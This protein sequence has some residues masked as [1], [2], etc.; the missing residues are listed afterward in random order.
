MAGAGTGPPETASAAATAKGPN[1][2]SKGIPVSSLF[3]A[4]S[5]PRPL[6][7]QRNATSRLRTTDQDFAGRTE[8]P[9]SQGRP[10]SHVGVIRSVP[11]L[12]HRPVDVLRRILD[13]AGLAVHAVLEV[14]DEE[15]LLAL[16]RNNLVDTGRAVSLRRLGV[17]GPVDRDRDARVLQRQVRGLAFL[18]VGHREADIGQAVEA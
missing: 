17:F 16:L 7:G 8:K 14:D 13:I 5:R 1:D 9:A 18:V 10:A 12:R 15:R 4:D 11:A 3:E 6:Q 2:R